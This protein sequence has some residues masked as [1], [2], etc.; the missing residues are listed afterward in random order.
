MRILEGSAE[1]GPVVSSTVL[2]GALSILTVA[3]V[4][5]KAVMEATAVVGFAALVALTY[6]HM[7]AWTT[8]VGVLTAVILFIPIRRYTMP[9]D[10]PFELEPYRVLMAFVIA[11]WLASLLVDPRVRL[12]ATGWEAPLGLIVAATLASVIANPGRVASVSADVAKGLTFFFS[13]LLFV[14]LYRSVIGPGKALDR[15]LK[16]LVGGGGVLAILTIVEARTHYNVF[17]HLHEVV[18]IL[19]L[20]EAPSE[21][22]RGGRLRVFASAQHPIALGAALVL[23]VPLAIYL[24]RRNKVWYGVA[25]LLALAT[26]A[27]VSRTSIVMLIVVGLVYLALRPKQTKRLWPLLIPV[28]LMAHIALPG[29]LGSLKKAFFPEGGLIAEQQ[30]AAGQ[31]GSGRIADLGPSLEEWSRRP[32]VG[33]GYSTRVVDL[34]RQNAAILDNQWLVTLLETGAV[35]AF[36]FIW[37]FW[38]AVRRMG[39]AA[40]ED[41]SDRGWLLAGLAASILAFAVGM[42][43]YDAFSFIQV[44]FLLFILLAVG[45]VALD[46]RPEEF[47]RRAPDPDGP[48]TGLRRSI[49]QRVA[50]A[51]RPPRP[52][53]PAVSTQMREG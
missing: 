34:E 48:R 39:R 13:F 23:L 31:R 15:L 35:G 22:S 49:G 38:R 51:R 53:R 27:T 18:P 24:A 1:R 3:I 45:S 30:G 4:N 52:P 50:G 43:T 10:L 40:K 20:V 37:L 42:F 12:R 14:Y 19:E 47:A 7:L 46:A 9:G 36:G 41:E 32:V 44:T 2:L 25:G 29:T 21:E 8:L 33:Q 6:R 16:V 28:L 5:D 17:N 26:I 11:G